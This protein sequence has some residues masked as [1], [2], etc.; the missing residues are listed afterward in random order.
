M[1]VLILYLICAFYIVKWS[2][3]HLHILMSWFLQTFSLKFPFSGTFLGR[4]R[5]MAGSLLE[6]WRKAKRS[7]KISAA[8]PEWE[9]QHS[10]T[11]GSERGIQFG[12]LK[13][14]HIP[15]R[16]SGG[17]VK[18][19]KLWQQWDRNNQWARTC[20]VPL[21]T[22]PWQPCSWPGSG[23]ESVL[24]EFRPPWHIYNISGRL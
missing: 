15:T 9:S 8:L 21:N 24:C 10:E 13:A 17:S 4:E 5:L 20:S 2:F 6:S 18:R 7:P 19:P 11:G 22:L 12:S 14:L 16:V 23:L 1:L 3:I